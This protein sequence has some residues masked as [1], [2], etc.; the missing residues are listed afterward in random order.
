MKVAIEV[1]DRKEADAVKLA[2]EDPAIKAF[3][4]V[5]GTLNRLPSQRAKERVLRFVKD[6]IDE[7]NE[8]AGPCE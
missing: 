2:M 1:K 3:V 8:T 7:M 6:H 4:I 5:M